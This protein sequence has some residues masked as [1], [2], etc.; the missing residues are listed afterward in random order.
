MDQELIKLFVPGTKIYFSSAT[1][2]V[3]MQGTITEFEYKIKSF[4]TTQP[5][6][7]GIK[8]DIQDAPSVL[9]IQFLSS[10]GNDV[11]EFGPTDLGTRL[12]GKRY[13]L[14]AAIYYS[15][16]NTAELLLLSIGEDEEEK[17]IRCDSTLFTPPQGLMLNH[18]RP[19]HIRINPYALIAYIDRIEGVNYLQKN[20]EIVLKYMNGRKIHNYVFTTDSLQYIEQREN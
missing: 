16:P 18:K 5:I 14:G 2:D 7:V 15:C 17:Y 13:P 19:F 3:D 11:L 9:Q 20:I 4:E 8:W 6:P 12:F 10:Y 1:T